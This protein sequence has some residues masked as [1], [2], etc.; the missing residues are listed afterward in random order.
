VCH[1]EILIESGTVLAKTVAR[2][3]EHSCN[4]YCTRYLWIRGSLVD[5]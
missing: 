2:D 4:Q 5:I 1:P 3:V